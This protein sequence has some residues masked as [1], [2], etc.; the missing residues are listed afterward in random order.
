MLDC[1]VGDMMTFIKE[2]NLLQKNKSMNKLS[3]FCIVKKSIS[4][5][6]QPIKMSFGLILVYFDEH[7]IKMLLFRFCLC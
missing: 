6:Q 5:V 2:V 7:T 4:L 3:G 1:N